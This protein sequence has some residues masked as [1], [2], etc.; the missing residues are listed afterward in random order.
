[1]Y[2]QKED[3]S[4]TVIGLQLMLELFLCGTGVCPTVNANSWKHSSPVK[5]K[6][7]NEVHHSERSETVLLVILLFVHEPFQKYCLEC[8]LTFQKYCFKCGLTVHRR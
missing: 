4:E 2:N 1:M 5:Q 7:P 6:F 8:G 3:R